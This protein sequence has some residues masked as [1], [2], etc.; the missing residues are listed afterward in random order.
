MSCLADRPGAVGLER[1]G[2]LRNPA[3]A[4]AEG[5]MATEVTELARRYFAALEDGATGEALAAFYAPEAVQEEFPNRFTPQGT[6][7]D[8]A[9]ILD[10]A[11]RGQKVMASQRYEILHTVADGNRVAVEFRWSGTLAVPV[12]SLPA[13]AEMRGRFA[14]FLE[15]RAGRIVAQ[16]NYDCFEPW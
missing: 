9:A 1:D 5:V 13:G 7:R 15:F 6:R 16:R 3:E 10:A 4:E 11:E 2:N 12:A 14:C 8:L